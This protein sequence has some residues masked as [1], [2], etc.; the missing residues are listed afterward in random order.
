MNIAI[1][2]LQEILYII[3]AEASMKR[4]IKSFITLIHHGRN[5]CSAHCL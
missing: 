3:L 2:Y 5:L 4:K 1:T